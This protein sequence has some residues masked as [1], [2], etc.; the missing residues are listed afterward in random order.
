[1]NFEFI[2]LF[3]VLGHKKMVIHSIEKLIQSK[4]NLKQVPND[5]DTTNSLQDCTAM[6]SQD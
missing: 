6:A 5:R 2:Y 1:M 3:V 4:G